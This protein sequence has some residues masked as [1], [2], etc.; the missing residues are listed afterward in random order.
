MEQFK[1]SIILLLLLFMTTLPISIEG[2]ATE[3]R[4]EAG[5]K[6]YVEEGYIGEIPA[7]VVLTTEVANGSDARAWEVAIIFLV[8]ED[9]GYLVD[10]RDNHMGFDKNYPSD[11]V[12]TIDQGKVI[13][14]Q[15]FGP[16]LVNAADMPEWGDLVWTITVLSLDGKEIY[17]DFIMR[18]GFGSDPPIKIDIG[19]DD[20]DDDKVKIGPR[21]YA[22]YAVVLAIISGIA[23]TYIGFTR[24]N[25]STSLEKSGLKGNS[26][27]K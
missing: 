14:T 2:Y 26:A 21:A 1:T 13:G 11:R 24:D 6:L 3:G 9:V 19:D 16:W 8:P 23:A 18:W 12:L 7:V 27:I 10:I 17:I 22:W 5:L 25:R 4:A 15:A 20:G